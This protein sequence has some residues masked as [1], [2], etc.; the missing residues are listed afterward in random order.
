MVFSVNAPVSGANTYDA[1]KAAAM[2]ATSSSTMVSSTSG[3]SSMS[4]ASSAAASSSSTT[5]TGAGYSNLSSVR[6]SV[7]AFGMGAG[8]IAVSFL[9]VF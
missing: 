7:V 8:A 5:K 3:A 1:F 4:T 6:S 9:F 2:G